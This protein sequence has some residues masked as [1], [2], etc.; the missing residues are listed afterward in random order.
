[1]KPQLVMKMQQTLFQVYISCMCSAYAFNSTYV[2]VH[3]FTD[4]TLSLN[5]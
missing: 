3:H 5:C 4:L 1:M 2:T